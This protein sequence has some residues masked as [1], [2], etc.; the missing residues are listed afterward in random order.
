[1]AETTVAEVMAELAALKDPRATATR[2]HRCRPGAGGTPTTR[3]LDDIVDE[4]IQ[5]Q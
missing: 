5:R 1:V 4:F 2:R 3:A